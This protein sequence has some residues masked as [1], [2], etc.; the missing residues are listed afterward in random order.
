MGGTSRAAVALLLLTALNAC[1]RSRAPDTNLLTGR[2]TNLQRSKGVTPRLPA[3]PALRPGFGGVIG[4]LADSGG[5]LPQ[6]PVRAQM[7]SSD[8]NAPHDTATPD[9]VGGFVFDSLPPGTYRLYARAFAHKPDS[10]DV[11]VAAG[12][13]ARAS[14]VLP[15]FQ[16]VR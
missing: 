13:V 9:S 5:A 14:I 1:Q 7:L 11:E 2:C 10:T 4:T 12:Q 15:F 16:C 6:Y 3:T 8:P